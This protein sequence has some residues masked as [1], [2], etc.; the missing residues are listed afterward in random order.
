MNV[1]V[2]KDGRVR[3]LESALLEYIELY[4]LTEKARIAFDVDTGDAAAN[5]GPLKTSHHPDR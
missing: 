5:F 2:P 1:R 4:G 3:R